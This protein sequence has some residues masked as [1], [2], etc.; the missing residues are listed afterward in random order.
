LRWQ[1]WQCAILN[2][3]AKKLP[4]WRAQVSNGDWNKPALGTRPEAPADLPRASLSLFLRRASGTLPT[5][6][7]WNLRVGLS[8][9]T[10]IYRVTRSS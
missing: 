2:C 9:T 5:V 7:R 4:A 8:T 10:A 3:Q 6:S 1:V